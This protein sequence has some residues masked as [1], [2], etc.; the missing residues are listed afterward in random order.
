MFCL[1]R[2]IKCC[3]LSVGVFILLLFAG[4]LR[5]WD[6]ERIENFTLPNYTLNIY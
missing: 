1:G 3:F 4:L 2:I 6:L 5:R